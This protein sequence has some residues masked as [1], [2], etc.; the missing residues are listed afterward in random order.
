MCLVFDT[1]AFLFLETAK[2]CGFIPAE[3]SFVSSVASIV[4]PGQEMNPRSQMLFHQ[5]GSFRVQ[6]L[7]MHKVKDK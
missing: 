3:S 2:L 1:P 7:W 5:Q 6:N 4:K